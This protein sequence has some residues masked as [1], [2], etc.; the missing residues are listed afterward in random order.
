MRPGTQ[1]NHETLGVCLYA[2]QESEVWLVRT[3]AGGQVH[4]IPADRRHEFHVL[5]GEVPADKSPQGPNLPRDDG[6]DARRA[7]R[8][9]ESLRSGLTPAYTDARHLAVGL[10]QL[11][12]VI[13][14]FLASVK[15]GGNVLL[16]RGEYGQGKTFSLRLVAE[17]ALASQYV[18]ATTEINSKEISLAKPQH[19][20][21]DLL[22]NLRIPGCPQVGPE[23]LAQVT[24]R[25]L[26]KQLK[27]SIPPEYRS[28]RSHEWLQKQIGCDPLAWLLSDPYIVEKPELLGLLGCDPGTHVPTAR[29]RHVWDSDDFWPNFGASTQGDFASFLLS[30]IGRLVRLLGFGGLVLVMDEMEKWQDL[31]WNEQTKAGNLL[32]GLIWGATTPVGQRKDDQRSPLLQHSAR[33][34]HH[35]FTTSERSHVG[36]AIAMTCRGYCGPEERWKQ[37]GPLQIHNLTGISEPQIAE[38]CQHLAPFYAQAFGLQRPDLATLQRIATDAVANWRRKTTHATRLAIQSA[39]DAFDAWRNSL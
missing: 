7:R 26:A 20:Y 25:L 4:R 37:Y 30:G 31:S 22:R 36:V 39:V 34:K 18:V 3:V 2:G 29:R 8:I 9:I 27:G 6:Q 24:A 28:V 32:G 33:C 13:Q 5:A 15:E 1:L 16:V 10:G 19:V 14:Q 17:I 21:A 38:Y 23:A 12:P 35:P 11:S